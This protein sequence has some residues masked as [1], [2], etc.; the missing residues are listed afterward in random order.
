MDI[1]LFLGFSS[2]TM[3][4]PAHVSTVRHMQV[5]LPSIVGGAGLLSHKACGCSVSGMLPNC[6]PKGICSPAMNMQPDDPHL[7]W[8]WDLPGFLFCANKME[9]KCH[10]LWSWFAFPSSL[11]SLNISF[12]VYWSSYIS[13]CLKSPACLLPFSL[14]GCFVLFFLNCK[15][16]FNILATNFF[17]QLHVLLIFSSSL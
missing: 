4:I 6:L 16:S 15:S 11:V 10:P 13:F 9:V 2:N 12:C 3:N 8:H 14:L 5:F 17:C 7:F 1:G